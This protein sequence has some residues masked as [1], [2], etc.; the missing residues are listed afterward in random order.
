MQKVVRRIARGGVCLALI[1]SVGSCGGASPD[2][3]R[4][5]AADG[6]DIEIT[7]FVGAGV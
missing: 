3:D 6:A 2:E 1:A 7:P 5:S 4:T